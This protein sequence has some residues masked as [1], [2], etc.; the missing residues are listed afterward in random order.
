MFRFSSPRTVRVRWPTLVVLVCAFTVTVGGIGCACLL[1]F[2][3]ARPTP[4]AV[5]RS[6]V[7]RGDL[8]LLRKCL[9]E[10]R[11]DIHSRYSDWH[12]NGGQTLLHDAAENGH[13]EMILLLLQR[14]ADPNVKDNL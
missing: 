3:F 13:P 12:S 11:F 6:A 14:G 4:H 10:Q 1:A 5:A 9:D 8:E 7:E 2:A